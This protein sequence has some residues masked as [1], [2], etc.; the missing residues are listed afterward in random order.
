MFMSVKFTFALLLGILALAP[1]H[2][3]DPTPDAAIKT[4]AV[5]A[6]VTLD[7]QVKADLALA[8]NCLAEGR[9]WMDKNAA[10]AT[11]EFKEDKELFRDGP[12]SYGRVYSVRSIVADRYVSVLRDDS[13][14]THG[15][16]PNRTVDTILWDKAAAKRISIRPFFTETTDNGPTMIAIRK[17]VIASIEQQKK[18]RG[19]GDT[20]DWWSK[21]LEPKLIGI[22][23]VT[24]APST[25]SGKSSGLTFHY[26]PY[27]VGAYAEGDYI[28][29][30]PWETLKS[31]LSPEGQAIFAGNRPKGDAEEN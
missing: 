11:K 17:A 31:Y 19:A 26:P 2:A 16:H 22:G 15:A 7:A 21:G 14:D 29:F 20:D 23:A 6:S 3:A 9:K 12:Y 25:V 18:A 4:K 27:A 24:L 1:A 5:D 10:D 28:A 13:M 30:V 8:A